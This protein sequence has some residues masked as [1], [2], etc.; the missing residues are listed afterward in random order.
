MSE[1]N[2]HYSKERR[3]TDALAQLIDAFASQHGDENC[4]YLLAESMAKI[5]AQS[6]TG[7]VDIMQQSDDEEIAPPWMVTVRIRSTPFS[8]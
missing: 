3:D 7:F 6:G 2:G 1:N 8:F 4:V 5:V